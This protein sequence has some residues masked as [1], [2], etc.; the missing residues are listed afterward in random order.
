MVLAARS[1]ARDARRVAMHLADRD[2]AADDRRR[3]EPDRLHQQR[4][5][6]RDVPVDADDAERGDGEPLVG[7]DEPGRA[8][9]HDAE[10]DHGG[11]EDELD[12]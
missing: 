3:D 7:A 12:R 4:E 6:D 1:G 8:R 9:D 5:R 2:R 10:V 11:D